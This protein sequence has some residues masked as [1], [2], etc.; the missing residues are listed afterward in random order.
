MNANVLFLLDFAEGPLFRLA[1]A[2]MVLELLRRALLGIYDL[3][4][5]YYSASDTT[6]VRRKLGLRITWFL[7]PTLILRRVHPHIGSLSYLACLC[8]LSL[9]FRIFAILVP[10]FMVA[11]VYLWERGFGLTWSTL[12]G[13]IA[14][15]LTLIT[16]AIGLTLFLGRL[17]SPLLRRLEPA[18]TFFKPLILTVPFLSGVIAMHP[19][20]SPFDYHLVLLIHVLSANLVFVLFP[21]TRMLHCMHTPLTQVMPEAAWIRDAASETTAPGIVKGGAAE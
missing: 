19:T 4:A 7:A 5:A 18:W 12:P 2:V 3:T 16:I 17:Y 14:D 9:A 11:H 15:V 10:A 13:R 6:A 1:F 20:W 21:F 8:A